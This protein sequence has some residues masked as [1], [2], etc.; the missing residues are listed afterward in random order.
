MKKTYLFISGCVLSLALN[1]QSPEFKKT[2]DAGDAKFKVKS[3]SLAVTDYSSAIKLI[4]KEY[5][6][7]LADKK[8]IPTDKKYM[9]AAYEKRAICYYFSNNVA[10][11]K[12][13]VDKVYALD[14]ANITAKALIAYD[15]YKAGK[16]V[17]GCIMM[18]Q[19]AI[20]GSEV[21]GK[22]YKDCFCVNE[23]L[24]LVKEVK[25]ANNLKKFDDALPLAERLV[26]LMPDS[27][28]AYSEKGT[29]LLGNGKTEEALKEFHK[30]ISLS[31]NNYLAYYHRAEIYEKLNKLDSA[32]E[33]MNMCMKLKPTWYEGYLYRAHICEELQLWASAI[34]DLKNC[35]KLHPSDGK[36][37][38]R[39]A[40]L[41]HLKQDDLY[42]ACPYYKSAFG[43]AYEEAEEMS[44]N[45]DNPKYMKT[46][47]KNAPKKGGTN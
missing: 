32:E 34:Y 31:K 8:P 5:D 24:M 14:T 2:M 10:S 40:E 4:E 36:L 27:G 43:K 38:F 28:I 45:C 9:A 17:D 33:D 26:M 7:L 46:H 41:I 47:L 25:S 35:V 22:E 11:M 29:A 6:K 19:Q 12:M 42:D 21:A 1:A 44:K 30:A 15:L 37:D 3:Y 23:G 18:K 13:D 20:K 39:I 16:K